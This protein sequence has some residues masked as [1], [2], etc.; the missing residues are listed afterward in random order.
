MTAHNILPAPL[1]LV[2]IN[3]QRITRDLT[4]R[5]VAFVYEDHE[6]ALDLLEI[7]LAD[8]YLQC[9]DDPLFQEGHDIRV[10][11]G[12]AD[13]LSPTKVGVIK[14]ISYDFPETG[15]PTITLKAY[16]KGCTLAS[17][18][19]QRV[20][21][22]PGGIRASD[23]ATAIA[24]EHG[25][26]P[27]V[28]AT[29]DRVPRLH[30]SKQSDAQWLAQLAKTAR[31]VDGKGTTGF[32]FYVEGE[33]LHFHPRG[34]EQPPVMAL[35]YF[36]DR[37]GV[38]R[39]FRPATRT[40]GDAASGQSTTAVGVNP[41]TKTAATT[42]AENASTP[43]RPVLGSKTVQGAGKASGRVVIDANTGTRVTGGRS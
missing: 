22:R 36:T 8:P 1:V 37:Q 31:T 16:D 13:N 6:A 40:Q 23:I 5:L 27:V 11:F 38:L 28:T 10:R 18:Q 7:T 19:V 12:Y 2:E 29:V 30:Q 20:W 33:E 9:L 39:S 41:A 3:G 15:V 35:E 24:T 26:T 34:L 14:E 43:E 21:Q 32:V 25:L 4:D 17:E 42:T